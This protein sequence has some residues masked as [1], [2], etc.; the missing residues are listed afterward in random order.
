ME[1]LVPQRTNRTQ[2]RPN[3]FRAQ[4]AGVGALA[5]FGTGFVGTKP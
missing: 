1:N 5:E 2:V 4:F 3:V